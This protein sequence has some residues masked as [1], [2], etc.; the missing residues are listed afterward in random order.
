MLVK[1]KDAS[2]L[3]LRNQNRTLYAN[4]IVQQSRLDGGC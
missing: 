1:N 4:Y 2:S 3:T